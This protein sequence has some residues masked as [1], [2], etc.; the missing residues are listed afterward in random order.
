MKPEI[1]PDYHKVI[2]VD[3]ASG[4]EWISRSTVTQAGPQ[5]GQ[6]IAGN[7]TS[8]VLTATGTQS[9]G[10]SLELHATSGGMPGLDAARLV[11][12]NTGDTRYR[13]WEVPQTIH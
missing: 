3:S 10:G 1:H 12:R 5:P 6:A 7:D 9:A 4:N 8:A 13:G 11:W 2:F